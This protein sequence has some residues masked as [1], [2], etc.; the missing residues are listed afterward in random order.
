MP[1]SIR[2]WIIVLWPAF[3]AA[4]VLETLVFSGFDPHDI[5]FFGLSVDADR[6]TVYSIAFFAFWA[7]TTLAGLL[8]WML[9]QPVAMPPIDTRTDTTERA[10]TDPL[11]TAPP[12]R[13]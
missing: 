6:D 13:A 2:E 12:P 4:C 1:R 9:A 5:H 7:V 11:D 10:S 3:M 8:T